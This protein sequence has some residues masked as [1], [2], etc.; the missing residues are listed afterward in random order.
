MRF[1]LSR[2]RTVI[3]IAITEIQTAALKGEEPMQKALLLLFVVV[4][5]G[6]LVVGFFVLREWN[7]Q[8][9]AVECLDGNPY[10]CA[11]WEA[12]AEFDRAQEAL[13]LAR[14]NYKKSLEIEKAPTGAPT[15]GED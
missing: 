15:Q 4:F 10:A 13:N 5:L 12:Q 14:D 1:M 3:K 7:S 2:C 6:V 9:I 11:L 8:K